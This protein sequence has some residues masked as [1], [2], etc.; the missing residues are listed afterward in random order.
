MD[1]AVPRPG[2]RS[3]WGSGSPSPVGLGVVGCGCVCLPLNSRGC[4]RTGSCLHRQSV[5]Y[6]LDQGAPVPV[7]VACPLFAGNG[8]VKHVV[9][10]LYTRLPVAA[11]GP[12]CW[13]VNQLQAQA[14]VPGSRSMGQ[15]SGVSPAFSLGPPDL[16]GLGRKGG[17]PDSRL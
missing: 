6:S 7:G 15:G 11:L 13:L 2:R 14:A 8:L 3:I 1:G 5:S 17:H 10:Q 16:Q 12:H 4:S 9:A